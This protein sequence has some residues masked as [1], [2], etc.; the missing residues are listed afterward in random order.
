MLQCVAVCC[1]GLMNMKVGGTAKSGRKQWATRLM[2]CSL[3]E[4]CECLFKDPIEPHVET[5]L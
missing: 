4:E 5:A 1:N 3:K 2:H